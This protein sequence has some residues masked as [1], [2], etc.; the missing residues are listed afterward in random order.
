MRVG[1]QFQWGLSFA[2]FMQG[3]KATDNSNIHFRL[4]AMTLLNTCVNLKAIIEKM[5][6]IFQ[7]S[8]AIVSYVKS[9]ITIALLL[10]CV[11]TNALTNWRVGFEFR[12]FK[13]AIEVETTIRV[14]TFA[15]ARRVETSG[16]SL[17]TPC[18]RR[19]LS[20]YSS[21]TCHSLKYSFVFKHCEQ[22]WHCE[23]GHDSHLFW[24]QCF[25]QSCNNHVDN[26][27]GMGSL[28]LLSPSPIG[29]VAFMQRSNML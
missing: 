19:F 5:H 18:Q 14:M 27:F 15:R 1:I 2:M 8:D 20:F 26:C 12:R 6:T 17:K 24:D 4:C 23:Y 25:F 21:P 22:F 11:S 10:H 9:L 3:T 16:R 28:C 7:F 13:F 29:F